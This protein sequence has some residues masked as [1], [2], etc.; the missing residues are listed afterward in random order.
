MNNLTSENNYTEGELPENPITYFEEYNSKLLI[1]MSPLLFLTVWVNMYIIFNIFLFF[2]KVYNDC[3]Q[4]KN[5]T[6]CEGEFKCKKG[7]ENCA[8]KIFLQTYT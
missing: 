8:G 6:I 1:W 3:T 4:K 5:K 2:A 7:C